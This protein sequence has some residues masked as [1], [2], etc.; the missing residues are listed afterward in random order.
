MM[1]TLT[2]NVLSSCVLLCGGFFSNAQVSLNEE[3]RTQEQ[4]SDLSL[5][6]AIKMLERYGIIDPLAS[7]ELKTVFRLTN[8][9]EELEYKENPI[10]AISKDLL[11][12]FMMYKD[13][14]EDLQEYPYI[15]IILELYRR[16]NTEQKEMQV[17][18]LSVDSAFI[19]E[20]EEEAADTFL[21]PLLGHSGSKPA[22][23][24]R[25]IRK[26][27]VQCLE[28]FA[29][30]GVR[31]KN[32][33][34]CKE[35]IRAVNP[36]DKKLFDFVYT[37][38]ITPDRLNATD[39]MGSTPLVVCANY[40]TADACR[41][42][43]EAGADINARNKYGNTA[44][45]A[46]LVGNKEHGKAICELLL[47]A[48]ADVNI[49]DN[50]GWTPLMFAVRDSTPEICMK[51][52]EAGAN[53]N[54]KD[55][56]GWTP[57]MIAAR[58]S[59][60]EICMKL[61]EAGANV[62][63][64]SNGGWTPLMI[65]ALNSASSEICMKLI[66]AGANVNEKDNDGWTPLMIA[67]RYS[68]PEI[69]MKLIEAG[70]H[71]NV[72]NN[73][74]WTPLMTAARYS[75]PEICMKL[76][77]AGAHVNVKNKGSLTPLMLAVQYS[78]P[79]VCM[80][81]IEAGADVNAKDNDGWTPLRIAAH[82]STLEVCTKL[83]GGGADVNIKDNKGV[84]PLMG[85]ARY[86]TPEICMKLIKA[87]AN[88]NAKNN[89]GW[90]PLMIAARYSTPEICMKLIKAGA[91]VNVKSKGGGCT[92]LMFAAYLGDDNKVRSL[93]QAGAD[94]ASRDMDGHT[95]LNYAAQGR[96]PSSTIIEGM[97]S[98]PKHYDETIRL[99]EEHGATSTH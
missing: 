3:T 90:T 60:S 38:I 25:T 73:N 63:A 67:A 78:T 59:S 22:K 32:V 87:G 51:L 64:K 75:A 83:I 33:E 84:T 74:G 70:A 36:I 6:Q 69:C 91:H 58:N 30:N 28:A 92:A 50:N 15:D 85:A 18:G 62:N 10:K 5:E 71:V 43:I 72:K 46:A 53:V 39:S 48:K 49:K 7:G 66:E 31:I 11:Y 42:L 44:L 54:E 8:S 29:K 65:A 68:A 99:L 13:G 20:Q 86:S 24:V 79:E 2:L 27:P 12:H 14:V 76:I 17:S 4:K 98:A 40:S 77:E 1:K 96:I 97:T 93:L 41:K 95:A 56:N 55:N 34:A 52:I 82:Y 57:L 9:R 37:F 61:I 89:D 88:V 19:K 21:A 94:V 81:L 47:N 35:N 45:I 26:V 23:P 16:A 80:K